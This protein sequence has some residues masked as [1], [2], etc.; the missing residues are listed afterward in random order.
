M[1]LSVET[2]YESFLKDEIDLSPAAWV[3]YGFNGLSKDEARLWFMLLKD[4]S[5][6]LLY[7]EGKRRHGKSML[8]KILQEGDPAEDSL[9]RWVKQEMHK[10]AIKGGLKAAMEKTASEGGHNWIRWQSAWREDI[11]NK[12]HSNTFMY[13]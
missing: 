6:A 5:D 4:W 10:A 8:D 9:R 11:M 12:I 3:D 2:L 1:P 13:R 7:E